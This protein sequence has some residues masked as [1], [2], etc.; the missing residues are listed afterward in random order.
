MQFSPATTGSANGTLMIASDDTDEPQL[1]VALTGEGAAIPAPEINLSTLALAFGSVVI[2]TDSQL[3]AIITN[4]GSAD[5]AVTALSTSGDAAFTLVSP[6]TLPV[7][8]AS[9]A[10]QSVTVEFSPATT[11]SANGSLVID[12]NDTDESQL[13]VALSGE[14]SSSGSGGG[15]S[16]PDGDGDGIADADDNCPNTSNSNQLNGDNDNAGDVCDSSPG[17]LSDGVPAQNAFYQPPADLNGDNGDVLWAEEINSADN[18]RI[19][20]MLYQSQDLHGNRIGISGWLAVPNSPKPA[21]GFP[22]VSFAHGTTGI[23]D[24]CAPTQRSTPQD[25]IALMEEFLARGFVVA[26]TDYQG[27]GTPG[28]HHYLIGPSEGRSVLDAARAARK[29]AGTSSELILFGHSQGGHAVIFANEIA[30]SYAADL[31]IVGTISSGSAISGTSGALVEATKTSIFKGYVVMAAVAQTAAYGEQASPLSRWLTPYGIDAANS[32]E[33]I[34]VGELVSTYGALSSGTLF[35]AGAPLQP[36]TS[37]Y[38]IEGDTTP[39]RRLGSSPMLM[40]HGRYDNQVPPSFLLP[41]VESTC[42]PGQAIQL[43]W[44]NTG[45]RVPYE[46]PELASPI[47]FNWIADRFAGRAAPSNCSNVPEP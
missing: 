9:G 31:D 35:V 3:D 40:L 33:S 41:W 22:I 10:S 16:N 47:V 46:A 45:H 1:T 44:F 24:M 2:G 37:A 34:C 42:S 14:G 15:N 4:S 43:E 13:T 39:G 20:K 17:V 23:A 30:A 7:T 12:S 18:G 26:A 29:V 28:V 27:L 38:D 19:W 36:G 32:L 25:T 6:T 5:L 11:G 8:I 21:S